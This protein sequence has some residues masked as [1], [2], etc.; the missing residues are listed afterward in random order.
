MFP[1]FVDLIPKNSCQTLEWFS[2][3]W[4]KEK[5]SYFG[6]RTNVSHNL[7]DSLANKQYSFKKM[8]TDE[9]GMESRDLSRFILISKYVSLLEVD[10]TAHD[11]HK[12]SDDRPAS[13]ACTQRP[14]IPHG[15]PPFLGTISPSVCAFFV[16]CQMRM[17]RGH[18]SWS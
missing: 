11:T 1:T 2:H 16:S 9:Y 17:L 15:N 13:V 6:A 3:Q 7:F 8:H 18:L 5:P 14:L 4:R 12:I 10:G